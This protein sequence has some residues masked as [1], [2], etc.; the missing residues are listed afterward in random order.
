METNKLLDN[1]N[2]I[3]RLPI[4]YNPEV[5]RLNENIPLELELYKNNELNKEEDCKP[6]YNYIFEPKLT[7]SNKL[8]EELSCYYTTDVLFLKD[9]QK[10]IKNIKVKHLNTFHKIDNYKIDDIENI[11]QLW[12]EIKNDTGFCEKYLYVDWSFAKNLNNNT[13]FL[14]LMSLY[15]I[16]SPILSLCLPIFIL[17]LPFFIIK[18]KGIELNMNQYIE[19]LKTL[20]SQQAIVKIFTSFNQIDF[21][22]KIYLLMSAAFY[23][24]SIY[25]N[26]LVCIRFYSNM[27]KIHDYLFK[28]RNYLNYTI[29][30]MKYHLDK[31]AKLTKYID[32]N[33]E[34]TKNLIIIETLFS[35]I[36]SISDFKLSFKKVYEIGH[37]MQVF[38]KLY[39]DPIYHN[40]LIYSFGFNAYYDLLY[41]LK[42]NI[43]QKLLHKT[44]YSK[45]LSKPLFREIYYPK[46]IHSKTNIKNNCDLNKNIIITG[47]NASGKTTFL[48][49]ILINVLLSQQVGFG[50]FKT[51]KLT[52]YDF[53]HCYLSIPETSGR[54]SLFQAEARRCKTILDTINNNELKTHFCIFDELYSGTNPDEAVISALAFIKYIIK[55]DLVTCLLTTH[56]LQLCESLK[57]NIN[58]NNYNMKTIMNKLTNDFEYTYELVR[59]ISN[60]KGGLKVLKDMNYPSEIIENTSNN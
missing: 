16:T 55:N 40:A 41:G 39:D 49:S 33:D 17:V 50:C 8:L 51:A 25:Q 53:F 9:T 18:L 31:S 21:N 48:K 14:Q 35:N 47:P 43:E 7:L 13:L 30:L 27:K 58:I 45:Q 23:V 32:F 52:P 57:T 54:D 37:I 12:K 44:T 1:I 28:V 36:D 56:Y 38:Y 3:F 2:S 42:T 20:L 10:L 26:I 11:I 46:F 60:I 59:G 34:V 4:T 6:I 15:N 22:Q 29:T 24:F 19:I 5:K